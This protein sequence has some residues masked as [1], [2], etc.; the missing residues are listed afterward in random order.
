MV[1]KKLD[2]EI[3]DLH[4]WK[5]VA[6]NEFTLEYSSIVWSFKEEPISTRQKI[7]FD[8]K[9]RV[10]APKIVKGPSSYYVKT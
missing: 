5:I 8:P 3:S 6:S 4:F 9:V 1:Y 2:L 7:E 10:N